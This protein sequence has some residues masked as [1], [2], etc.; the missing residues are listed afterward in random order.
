M[1]FVKIIEELFI[2]SINQGMKKDS[3]L[4]FW[5]LLKQSVA[6]ED[7]RW[8]FRERQVWF[9]PLGE[10]VGREQNGGGKNFQRPKVI[11][12]KFDRETFFAIPLTS[13]DITSKDKSGKFY[14]PVS[15][16][17]GI[18]KSNAILTQGRVLDQKRLIRSI[19]RLSEED[20]LDLESSF[21]RLFK[22]IRRPHE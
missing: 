14:C 22:K 3:L 11:F 5:H 19:G 8:S 10:N 4:S 21:F 12:R 20:F 13:K 9:T 7:K 6:S 2:L 18:K 17:N 16:Q 15:W 1:F